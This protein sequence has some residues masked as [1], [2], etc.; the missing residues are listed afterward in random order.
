MSADQYR[1]RA[2]EA[3]QRGERVLDLSVKAG[4]ERLAHEWLALAEQVELFEWRYG[5]PDPA[6]PV[7]HPS[8][9]VVQQQQQIRPKKEEE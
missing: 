3:H 8:Q 7:P 2:S 9:A 5:N 4:W 1:R 6:E